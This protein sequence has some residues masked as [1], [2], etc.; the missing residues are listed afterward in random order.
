MLAL[1]VFDFNLLVTNSS[2]DKMWRRI[3]KAMQAVTK[4]QIVGLTA[5]VFRHNYCTNLC[6]QPKISI[7]KIAQ[8]MGETEAVTLKVYNHMILEKE[9]TESAGNDAMNF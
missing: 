7:K 3:L 9:A 6:Y 5:R 8:L 1:T 4:E 2:Y